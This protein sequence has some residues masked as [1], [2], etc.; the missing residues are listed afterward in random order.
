MHG[1]NILIVS[2][3]ESH[4]PDAGNRRRLLNL[5][6]TLRE[7]GYRPHRLYMDLF[8]GDRR[9]MSRWR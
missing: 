7:L 9:A 4:P 2:P 1:G 5:A 6:T 3:A 8:P